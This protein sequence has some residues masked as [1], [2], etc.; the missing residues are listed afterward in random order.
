VGGSAR[1]RCLGAGGAFILSSL[2]TVVV[3]WNLWPVVRYPE[4]DDWL[5]I[6]LLAV[7]LAILVIGGLATRRTA[8]RAPDYLPIV[9]LE[10]PYLANLVFCAIGFSGRLQ[11]GAYLALCA[12]APLVADLVRSLDRGTPAFRAVP[13]IDAGGAGVELRDR[14]DPD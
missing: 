14:P 8:R 10:V 7:A 5:A 3:L 12:A 4:D 11:S 13:A 6:P 2:T 9:A 1:S